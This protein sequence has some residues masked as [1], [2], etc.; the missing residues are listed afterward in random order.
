MKIEK[1]K[2]IIKK[3]FFNVY[4]WEKDRD[5]VWVGKG[6]TAGRDTESKSGSRLQAIRTE[7]DL[8]FE[9]TKYE[10]VTWA[11]VW[12]LTD[13]ATQAPLKWKK[14]VIKIRAKVNEIEIRKVEK[15]SEAK[16]L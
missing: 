13:W 15:I 16:T 4:F 5:R 1:E 11:E 3:N 2:V 7:P 12:R 8:G 14:E 9:L 10:I 6:Q